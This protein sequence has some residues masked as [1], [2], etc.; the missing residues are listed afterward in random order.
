MINQNRATNSVG[1]LNCLREDAV[2]FLG[3]QYSNP[4]YGDDETPKTAEMAWLLSTANRAFTKYEGDIFSTIYFPI[5]TNFTKQR[6]TVGVMRV[7]FHWARYFENILPESKRGIVV[8]LEN[9]CDDPFTYQIDGQ[10]VSPL[11]HG[12]LH[13]R[14]FEKYMRSASFE[15]VTWIEDGTAQGLRVAISECPYKIRVYPSTTFSE[16]YASKTPA[17]ITLSVACVFVFTVFTFFLYDTLVER[18]QRLLVQKATQTHQI[19]SSLFPKNV[20]DRLLEEGEENTKK[21]GFIAPNQRI[22]TFLTDGDRACGSQV[23]ADLFPHATVLFA[24]ISG[25]TAWSSSRE[26]AQVFILLQ[27]VYQAFDKIAKQRKVF[28]VETIGDSVSMNRSALKGIYYSNMPHP[29][30]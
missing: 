27:S 23:I 6:E 18:R 16:D 29:C 3:M 2:I 24:D 15:N 19:V 25:F 8:V 5:Y 9:N 11:G 17:V 20:R 1:S 7:V 4:G 22:K 12:D 10:V 21:G 26:P 30:P 13:D 28:K 14:R